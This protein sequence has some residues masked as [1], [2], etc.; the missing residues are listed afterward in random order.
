[1]TDHRFDQTCRAETDK[2]VTDSPTIVTGDTQ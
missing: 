1:M 2:A